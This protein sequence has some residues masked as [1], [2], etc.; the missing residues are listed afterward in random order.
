MNLKNL[1]NIVYYIT[2]TMITIVIVLCGSI[3]AVAFTESCSSYETISSYIEMFCNV[4]LHTAC[5]G[6]LIC[7]IMG[8]VL[9]VIKHLE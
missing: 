1:F 8:L 9:W 4:P 5:I 6:V 2:I 3:L 7:T